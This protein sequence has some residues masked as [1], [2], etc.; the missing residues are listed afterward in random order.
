MLT[1]D[2]FG[3]DKILKKFMKIGYGQRGI[4]ENSGFVLTFDSSPS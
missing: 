3:F 2:G 4:E 1:T